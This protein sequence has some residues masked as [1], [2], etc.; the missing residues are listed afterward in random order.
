ML[1]MIVVVQMLM[2]VTLINVNNNFGHHLTLAWPFSHPGRR[3]ARVAAHAFVVTCNA[4]EPQN[5]GEQVSF[6]SLS[7]S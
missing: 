1:M 5:R 3:Q 6:N 4:R 7:T 2:N